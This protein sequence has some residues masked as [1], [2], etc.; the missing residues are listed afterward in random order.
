MNASGISHF[1][2][3]PIDPCLQCVPST[4]IAVLRSAPDMFAFC[5]MAPYRLV[6][7]NFAFVKEG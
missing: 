2:H 7:F 1:I 4:Q 3:V 6:P 5:S